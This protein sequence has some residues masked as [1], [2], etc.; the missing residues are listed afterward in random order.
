MGTL[1]HGVSAWVTDRGA[2]VP[3]GR[4]W[5]IEWWVGA[6]DRWY[7]PVTEA[8]SRQEAPARAAVV[9]GA[10]RVPGGDVVARVA[11]VAGADGR[12]ATVIE[13][14]NHSPVAVA[15]GWVVIGGPG[16]LGPGADHVVDGIRVGL[17]RPPRSLERSLD[18]MGDVVG[19]DAADLPDAPVAVVPLPHTSTIR[20]VASDAGASPRSGGHR[21]DSPGAVASIDE[22]TRGW[23][24]L[25]EQGPALVLPDARRAE[26][27]DRGRVAMH[28]LGASAP[29]TS[30]G[31]P[32]SIGQA[33][34]VTRAALIARAAPAAGAGLDDL[35]RSIGRRRPFRRHVRPP[36]ELEAI[37]RAWCLAVSDGH[38]DGAEAALHL[39]AACH[40]MLAGRD[41]LGATSIDALGAAA[42]VLA[43]VGQPD[44]ADEVLG[45]VAR[46]AAPDADAGPGAAAT[47]LPGPPAGNWAVES[48]V[49][50]LSVVDE[51][52]A[53]SARGVDLLPGWTGRW[54]GQEVEVHRLLTEVG[55]ASFALRWHGD[56]PAL[57]WEID[58][59]GGD[60]D[61]PAGHLG[62]TAAAIDATWH[63]RRLRGEALLAPLGEPAERSFS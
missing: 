41:P 34:L 57:L 11:A 62:V 10:V 47:P 46:L 27:F 44:A 50:L 2:V 18:L 21:V 12:A 17:G 58:P 31:S 53:V 32:A 15:I 59:P 8:T 25:L 52:V 23:H 61:G 1:A 39:A 20:L 9:Q 14:T 24:H 5:S 56:R 37:I 60:G 45:R 36:L 51:L 54:W 49:D 55:T 48:A 7:R 33:A 43:L 6:A 42:T 22:V 13:V 63:D 38:R 3:V 16:G 4:S 28:L 30:D 40:R 19:P 29:V 35:E 26:R